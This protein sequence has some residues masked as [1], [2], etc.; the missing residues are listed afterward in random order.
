LPQIY[1]ID[2][3]DLSRSSTVRKTPFIFGDYS[4]TYRQNG[5]KARRLRNRSCIKNTEF[6]DAQSHRRARHA[7]GGALSKQKA[8]GMRVLREKRPD[9]TLRLGRKR[10]IF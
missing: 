3:G 6:G 2:V 4:P 5:E 9:F 1:D 8:F 10:N 7:G